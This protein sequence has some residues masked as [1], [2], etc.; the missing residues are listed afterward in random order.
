MDSAY[1]PSRP[2][3][4]LPIDLV[5]MVIESLISEE[6][7][8]I[9]PPSHE[10]TKTLLA[11]TRVCRA[12]YTTAS[13][14]LWRSCIHLDSSRRAQ[15][16]LRALTSSSPLLP[17]PIL[18][19]CKPTR[20]FLSPF[21]TD[22][23]SSVL[24]D[25]DLASSIENAVSSRRRSSST[26]SSSSSSWPS[27]ALDNL[28][29]ALLVKKILI[30]LA[31]FLR[32]L[33]IDMPLRSLYPE[34]DHQ[35]V[36]K[37]LRQGF[38]ALVNLE[39]FVSV[40]DELYLAT[41]EGLQ[42]EEPEVWAT[43]WPKLRRL[44]I[45]NPDLDPQLGVWTNMAKTPDLEVAIFTRADPGN[46][47]SHIDLKQEWLDAVANNPRHQP[48]RR[49]ELAF[50]DCSPGLPDFETLKPLWQ[51]VDPENRIRVLT[52]DVS[53]P[54]S[55]KGYEGSFSDWPVGPRELCQ[56][57]IKQRALKGKA[58]GNLASAYKYRLRMSSSTS[59]S[60]VI[61]GA[62]VFGTSTALHLI[63]KYP[64]A[65]ITLV[66]RNAFDAPTKVAASWD[67]NKV[68]R[69]DYKDIGYTSMGLEAR[70]VWLNDPLWSPFYH[71]SGIYWISATGF[72]RQV[73]ENFKRLGVKADLY[74]LGVEEA[75][76]Q[77]G[78]IFDSAD[79]TGIKEVLVNKSSGWAAAKDV[80]QKVLEEAIELGVNFL[81]AEVKSLEFDTEGN[82]T[83]VKTSSGQ[84]L[85]GSRIILSTGAFTPKLLVDSAPERPELHAGDRIIAA[86]VTEAT[87]RL[88]DGHPSKFY[89][90]PVCIQ[91]VPQARGASNGAVPH[92]QDKT[93]K[94]W[95]QHIFKNTQQHPSGLQ[96]SM[97]PQKA[98]YGQWDVPES[99]KDDVRFANTVI[100]AE[101]GDKFPMDQ[102]R[103]CWEALTPSQDF[104]ISPHSGS[105]NLYI[106]TCGSFH[107]WKFFPI[108]GKY[109]VQMLEQTLDKSLQAKWAW[110]RELPST[111]NNRV[112]PRTELRDFLKD[113]S[114]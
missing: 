72:A 94:F 25:A 12:T 46:D 112:W 53:P 81:E 67:W 7:T 108:I 80:L 28:P 50:V 8:A 68:V 5:L 64:N 48:P 103:I 54:S 102:F 83:G 57:W 86:A 33:I 56:S 15:D 43:C 49:L 113:D 76:K 11:F 91:E 101:Q 85:E 97:P 4:N 19:R 79:Y 59:E 111:D 73:L 61:V 84:S 65:N 58:T 107:G 88:G 78:G 90:G 26:T 70:D 34:Q 95:G 69:S 110:D 36:R 39:E 60:Y 10:V 14:I 44:A 87:S 27:S 23:E 82:C 51:E 21:V 89:N 47:L 31:P 63:R 30:A 71:E 99:L 2:R 45:Y 98:D 37:I 93:V 105:K 35:G 75:R 6:A 62:G 20:A 16:F 1:T 40:Q 17:S 32:T 104:I 114:L 109:V 42:P 29:V 9:L 92:T 13:R 3:F 38:E 18:R 41:Q 66:D 24:D 22:E 106:A 100:F 52:I 74:S 96:F 77:F 55:E